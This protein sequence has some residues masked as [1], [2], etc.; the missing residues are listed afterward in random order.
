MHLCYNRKVGVRVVKLLAASILLMVII[1][2]VSDLG[3]SNL[4]PMSDH[5]LVISPQLGISA[6]K[7]YM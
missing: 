7:K 1:L 6:P 4:V 3:I 5:E 2:G